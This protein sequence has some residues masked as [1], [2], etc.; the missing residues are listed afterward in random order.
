MQFVHP[1]PRTV[2]C[3]SDRMYRGESEIKL[4]RV[5]WGV[6]AMSRL[7]IAPPARTQLSGMLLNIR[8]S[9]S[10]YAVRGKQRRNTFLFQLNWPS[11]AD[12][13]T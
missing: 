8:C 10:R 5:L 4:E 11:S 1:G 2:A 3:Q 12:S 6:R 7:H 9:V 13:F